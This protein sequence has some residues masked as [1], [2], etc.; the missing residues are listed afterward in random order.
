MSARILALCLMLLIASGIRAQDP[1]ERML[2]PFH[3]L[4]SDDNVIVR[5]IKSDQEYAL[6]EAQ[7]ID[8]DDVI[9]EVENGILRIYVSGNLFA[10]KKV[11]IDLGYKQLK[12]VEAIN[13]SDISTTSLMKTDTLYVVLKTGGIL[14]LD[15]DIEYLNSQVIEGSLF[16]ADGYATVHDILVASSATVSAFDL[17][18]DIVNVRASTGGT[19]KIYAEEELNAEASTKGYVMYKGEPSKITQEG[20]SGSTI[21][22][23]DD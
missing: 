20:R 21:I 23:S 11:I 7:G 10:R 18:S 22:A 17:E 14:Y 15:A 16:S 5:L 4:H 12:S 9:T 8:A 13:G 19:A 3:S 2:D 6:I 1:V